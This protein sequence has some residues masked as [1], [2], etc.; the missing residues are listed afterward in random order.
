[1][2]SLKKCLCYHI[3]SDIFA[4]QRALI[5]LRS[6]KQAIKPRRT[7]TQ[8]HTQRHTDTHT[9]RYTHGLKLELIINGYRTNL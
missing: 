5:C 1:M 2:F 8:T 9:H 3:T 4:K 6:S 7:H